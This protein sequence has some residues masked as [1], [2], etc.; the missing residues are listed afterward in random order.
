MYIAFKIVE[1]V[2]QSVSA[3]HIFYA[4]DRNKNWI[5]FFF[6][7]PSMSHANALKMENARDSIF[8]IIICENALMESLDVC[9]HSGVERRTHIT[10]HQILKHILVNHKHSLT[11]K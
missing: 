3:R 2:E 11:A 4:G 10:H 9:H 6:K 7:S 5:I 8:S 1:D